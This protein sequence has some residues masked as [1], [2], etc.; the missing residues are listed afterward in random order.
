MA[1]PIAA[2]YLYLPVH[3]DAPERKLSLAVDGREVFACDIAFSTDPAFWVACDVAPWVGRAATLTVDGLPDAAAAVQAADVP[4]AHPDLYREPLRP[5]VHFTARRGWLND[6]NGLICV[7]GV[8]HL[9]FQHNPYGWKWGNMHWGHAVS[10]DLLHWRELSI[11]LTPTYGDWAFSGS[12][13]ADGD[14]L[15][16]AFTSTGRGECLAASTDGGHTFTELPDNPII[17]H[18]GRDPRLFRH[19]DGWVIAVYEV[20]DGANGIA[21]YT[22]PDLRAWTRRSWIDG[23]FECPE[24]FPLPADTGERWVLYAANGDYLLG[25]FDGAVFTPDGPRQRFTHGVFY[26]SQTFS[27][28]PG[29]R[30]QMAWGPIEM[31]GMSFNQQMLFPVELSLRRVDGALRLC[32]EPVRELAAL[33][34]ASQTVSGTLRAGD[35]LPALTIPDAGEVLL[36][37]APDAA[38]TLQV[39]TAAVTYA[40]GTVTIGGVSAPLE[41]GHVQFVV[42]R[43][44]IELFAGACYL[45]AAA[46]LGA[47][48]KPVCLT[49]TRGTLHATVT[50]TAL[51]RVWPA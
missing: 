46:L 3:P 27:G 8:Y 49:C 37:V 23:F 12:A 35:S 21:I 40:D 2:R 32:A 20:V 17:T 5:Q 31:P 28:T 18:E 24:L 10:D 43:T 29:R 34:G 1:F 48:E 11:A 26:A 9:Y 41:A 51:S 38:W 6:P 14:R 16:I 7:D 39:G 4:P 42:D 36:D 47:G 13:A 19:G 44:T 25:D 30:V 22:S 50:T 33:R 15:L 45:P